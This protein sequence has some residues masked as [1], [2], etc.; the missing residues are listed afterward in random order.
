ME[1]LVDVL[2]ED[3]SVIVVNK[4]SG[5]LTQ[6]PPGV[7]SLEVRIREY[8]RWKRRQSGD[9]YVGVPHRLDR[10]VS[11]VMVFALRRK[12]ASR[13]S[14]QFER[15]EVKKNYWAI[16]QSHLPDDS[17]TLTDHVRKIPGRALAEVVAADHVEGKPAILRY[18][19]KRRFSKDRLTANWVEIELETGRT[20]Q[21][22]LQFASRGHS[23]LGDDIYGSDQ[24]FGQDF[25]D[26]RERQIALHARRLSFSHPKTRHAMDFQADLPDAWRKWNATFAHWP[27]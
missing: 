26:A 25:E 22:R 15:R 2:H 24:S 21:I 14:K 20:H 27:A 7:D 18:D 13:L 1:Q 12:M 16:V 11:G 3:E 17:G 23:V 9:V 19:V 10:P 8:L 6:S 5:I 4:P